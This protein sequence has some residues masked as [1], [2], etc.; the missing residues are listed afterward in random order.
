ME[1]FF[2]IEQLSRTQDETGKRYLEFLRIAAMSAGIY[3]LPKG[4]EDLQ[5]PHQEDEIYYVI[6][7]RARMRVGTE[8]QEA[9]AGAIVFVEARKE[10]R[11][12][13]IEEDLLVLVFFAPA[14]T[15]V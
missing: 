6:R 7:G 13:D 5:S 2:T 10:H 11:F 15:D 3:A 14:E 1:R 8:H 12:Y 9:S 4:S